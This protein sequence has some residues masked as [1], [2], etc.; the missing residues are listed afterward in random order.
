MP[1]GRVFGDVL[2]PALLRVVCPQNGAVDTTALF[3]DG[4]VGQAGAINIDGGPDDQLANSVRNSR[5]NDLRRSPY[6][7]AE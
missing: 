6:Q 7:Q 4:Q 5:R 3:I 2:I 1:P